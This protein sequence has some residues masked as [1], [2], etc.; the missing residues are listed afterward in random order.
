MNQ[1]ELLQYPVGTLFEN[2]REGLVWIKTSRNSYKLIKVPSNMSTLKGKEFTTE[3][4]NYTFRL[5]RRVV[6][7]I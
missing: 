7:R 1:E 2:S 6:I 3:D 5:S 4:R